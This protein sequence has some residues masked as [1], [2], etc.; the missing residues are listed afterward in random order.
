LGQP[1]PYD[2]LV[3]NLPSSRGSHPVQ[4]VLAPRLKLFLSHATLD[5]EHVNV[6]KQQIEALG[7][8][9]YLAERDPKLGTSIAA[10]VGAAI[11]RSDVFVALIT[12][13]GADSNY[14]QQEVGFALAHRKVTIPIVAKGVD[15]SR[16]GMLSEVECLELD[17]DAPSEALAKMSASLQPFVLK[18]M[19]E[20]QTSPTANV[21]V[22]I[23]VELSPAAATVLVLGVSLLIWM[24]I[25]NGGVGRLGGAAS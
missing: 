15:R 18:Q 24:L 11:E 19:S 16:L 23:N 21:E 7:I 20:M 10:K 12:G 22:A 25:S 13:A 3:S 17:L 6:V 8:D 5:R 2:R 4:P 1:R 9:V 14:V